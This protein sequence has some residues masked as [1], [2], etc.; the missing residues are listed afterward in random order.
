MNNCSID[1][2]DSKVGTKLRTLVG[3]NN[4]AY[5]NYVNKCF[6]DNGIKDD[7]KSWYKKTFKKE[8]KL[9]DRDFANRMIRYYNET[10][11]RVGKVLRDNA[12]SSS[13]R[14]FAYPSI[15]DR[16]EGIRH[17]VGF[18]LNHFIA[19]QNAG[20]S[21][22]GNKRDY[23]K[24]ILVSKYNDVIFN[25]IAN[26]NNKSIDVVKEEYNEA[27]NKHA[28]LEKEFGG[29]NITITGRNLLAVHDELNSEDTLTNYFNECLAN[30]NLQSVLRQVND[31]KEEDDIEAK[32]AEE[33]NDNNEEGN[34]D[35]ETHIKEDE[36][37]NFISAA[38]SHMGN[39]TSYTKHL[40]TKITNY[41]NSLYKLASPVEV[42][43]RY[44]YDTN[45]NFGIPETMDANECSMM[46][47]SHARF[48]NQDEMIASIEQIS[49]QVP[50][51]YAFS[52]FAN[53]LKNDRDLATEVF[54][55]FAKTIMEKV[56]TTLSDEVG[57]VRV[58]NE[59]ANPRSAMLY[60]MMNDARGTSIDIPIDIARDTISKISMDVRNAGIRL[61]RALESQDLT[62]QD[63]NDINDNV[64]RTL[65]TTINNIKNVI[66]AYFPTVQPQAIEQYINENNNAENDINTKLTNCTNLLNDINEIINGSEDT[67]ANYLQINAKIQDAKKH[68]DNLKH[69]IANNNFVDMN[70]MIDMSKLYDA[71][72]LSD[73]LNSGI[74]LLMEKLLP[75]STVNVSLNSRNV[76]GNQSSDVINN[77]MITYLTKMFRLSY[78]DAN[79]KIINEALS[80]WGRNRFRSHQ[81]DYSGIL[82]EHR[83]DNGN[84]INYGLF[85]DKEGTLSA[86][87]ENLINISLFNGTSN[88]DIDTNSMYT[89]QTKGDFLPTALINFFNTA[90]EVNGVQT[91]QDNAT[92]FLRT[93]SDAP[94]TFCI[95]A[96]KYNTNNF[97]TF[98]D[99]KANIDAIV[100]SYN[101]YEPTNPPVDYY[102]P[103]ENTVADISFRDLIKGLKN[104]GNL[105]IINEKAIKY[106]DKKTGEAVV[107]F[108]YKNDKD[109]RNKDLRNKANGKR[110]FFKG[111]VEKSGKA[112]Y[113]KDYTFDGIL[114]AEN[115]ELDEDIKNAIEGYYSKELKLHDITV[116]G[117]TYSQT[118]EQVNRESPLFTRFENEVK[119]ELL[120]TAI[121]IDHYFETTIDGN[122]IFDVDENGVRKP[123]FKSGASNTIGYRN[124]HLG[125]NGTVLEEVKKGNKVVG[126]RLAGRVFGSEK[127]TLN[128]DENGKVVHRNYIQEALFSDEDGSKVNDGKIHFLYGGAIA[129]ETG[130]YTGT[131]LN[132][133][134]DEDG[135]VTDIVLNDKQKETLDNALEQF[136][137]AYTKQANERIAP[138]KE[139]IKGVEYNKENVN[140]Y[141]INALLAHCTYDDLFE[142]STLFYKNGQDVLKRAKEYQGSGVPYGIVNYMDDDS[143]PNMEVE[144]SYLN[145]GVYNLKGKEE[146]RGEDGLLHNR[147]TVIPTSIQDIFKGTIFDGIKQ[148]TKFRAITI[149]NTERT[150]NAAAQNGPLV[151]YLTKVYKQSGVE[152]NK[153]REMANKLMEG[154]QGTK[155]NDAQSYITVQEWVRRIA[156]RGQLKRYMPLIQKLIK[157][158]P[159]SINEANEFV[160]VQKNFYYDMHYDS[161]YGIVVP[162]QIKNAEFVLVPQFIRG[163]EL[164]AVYNMMQKANLQQL[165]TVETSKAAN[166][167]LLTIW[168]NDGKMVGLTEEDGSVNTDDANSKFNQFVAKANELA[169][170]NEYSYKYLY[171][172]QETPQHLNA[173]NKFGIQI[174]KKIIDNIDL[175]D[176]ETINDNDNELTKNRKVL[177][178]IKRR[179]MNLVSENVRDSFNN[180]MEELE[181]ETDKDGNI[182]L[183]KGEI[184][185]MNKQIFYDKL[186]E[187]L[188]R[189]GADSN[190][191]DYVTLV[192][193]EPKMKAITVDK[194]TKFESVVQSVFNSRITRQKL[195]GFHVAQVTNMGFRRLGEMTGVNNVSYDKDLAYHP[196]DKNGNPQGYIEVRLPYSTFGIDIT[197]PYYKELR[198]GKT[199]AEFQDAILAELAENGLDTIIGYR[200]PTEGKQSVCNMKVV[201]FLDDTQ[202][203]TIIVPDDWVSQTGSDFDIDSVYGITQK[204]RT[205]K[206]GKVVPIKF[207]EG[208]VGIGQYAN[209]IRQFANDINSDN[210]DT[211]LG[212][213]K[214]VVKEAINKIF[215]ETKS[216]VGEAKAEIRADKQ[217]EYNS[218]MTEQNDAF[219]EF[220]TKSP[221]AKIMGNKNTPKSILGI[222]HIKQNQAVSKLDKDASKNDKFIAQLDVTN[223]TV[224]A[225][226][227]KFKIDITK[228][229][230]IS[231]FIESNEAII[232][233]LKNQKTEINELVDSELEEIF[234]NRQ[235]DLEDIASQ[236]GL[237]SFDDFKNEAINNPE[238]INSRDARTNE[239]FNCMKSILENPLALE[240]N[241]SRSNF[242]D[243]SDAL[244]EYMNPN[245]AAERTNRS[246]YNPFDQMSYQEEAM[247]GAKLKAFSVTLDTFCSVCNTVKPIL[248]KPIYVVYNKSDY[249]DPSIMQQRFMDSTTKNLK[250]SKTFGVRHTSYG[251]SADNKCAA[252]KILTAY[253]SQTTAYILDAIKSGAIPNVNDYTFAVFK[254]LANAGCDYKTSISFIMQ[255]GISR[256][257]NAYNSSHSVF[258]DYQG[259]NPINDAI[260]SIAKDLGYKV[261]NR[262]SVKS[263]LEK[264]DNDYHK[265][266]NK[267]FA[268]KGE[269]INIGLTYEDTENLPIIVDKQV[270]RLKDKGEFEL[271][272][273]TP[274][275]ELNKLN[276]KKALFDLGVVLS[277]NKLYYTANEIGDIARC[278]NPDK[279]GAKQDVYSTNKI[280]DDANDLITKHKKDIDGNEVT[281]A[282]I[283]VNKDGKRVHILESIYPGISE[284]TEDLSSAGI[285]TQ[286][287]INESSYPSLYSYLKYASGTSTVVAREVLPTQSIN[288]TRLVKGFANKLSGFDRALSPK[289]YKEVQSYA[290]SDFYNEAEFI[291]YPIAYST[292]E[293]GKLDI[294]LS[295][296]EN[297]EAI[298]NERKRIFGFGQNINLTIVKPRIEN[299][300]KKNNTINY[301]ISFEKYNTLSDEE[302]ANYE[303]VERKVYDNV[304]FTVE[305]IN[306]PTNEELASFATFS[307]AQKVQFI[308]SNFEDTGIFSKLKVSLY[309]PMSRGY[310]AGSQTIEYIQ[311]NSN[312]N[313][314]YQEFYNAFFDNNPL[315]AMTAYDLVKY[316]A[317]V[318]GFKMSQR[319]ISK[320]IDNRCLIG[321]FGNAGTGFQNSVYGRIVDFNRD[322]SHI[323][324]D[325][326]QDKLYEEFLRSHPNTD[327][328]KLYSV[329]K[330]NNDKYHLDNLSAD[331]VILRKD[332]TVEGRTDKEIDD[333][334]IERAEK[335]GFVTRNTADNSIHPNP[336]VKFKSKARGVE[337]Y[338]VEHIGDEIIAYPLNK[339]NQNEH[340]TWSANENYNIH[341]RSEAYQYI[342]A[343]Y[344]AEKENAIIDRDFI[345]DRIAEYKENKANPYYNSIHKTKSGTV[346][347]VLENMATG[348]DASS[349]AIMLRND[350]IKH[351][352]SLDAN[353]MFRVKSLMLSKYI[354]A[355]NDSSVQTISFP[356][357]SKRTFE[358]IKEDLSRYNGHFLGNK[359]SKENRL[360]SAK[361]IK[362]P[363]LNKLYTE[364][365][366]NDM[367]YVNDVYKVVDITTNDSSYANAATVEEAD[368]SALE[369]INLAQKGQRDIRTGLDGEAS[370]EVQATQQA[371]V[372][373]IKL[374]TDSIKN[375]VDDATRI[376]AEYAIKKGKE[377]ET[378]LNQF[379]EDPENPNTYL[380]ASDKRVIDIIKDKPLMINKFFKMLNEVNAYKARFAGYKSCE[381]STDSPAVKKYVE[382]I[383]K[384]YDNV[385][386]LDV[387]KANHNLM[388]NYIAKFSTNPLIREGVLDIADNFYKTYGSMWMFHDIAE[389]GNP[390]LQNILKDVYTHIEA[391]RMITDK[392]IREVKAHIKDIKRRAKAEGFNVDINKIVNANGM[393]I[394]D[395]SQE[396]LDKMTELRRLKNE[397]AKLGKGYGS[398][399]YL[400]AKNDYDQYKA[401][402][403]H[404]EAKQEYYI[405]KA[406]LER[407]MINKHPKIY[408]RYMT[409]LYKQL[410]IYNYMTENGIPE[411]KQAELDKIQE[412]MIN[413]SRPTEYY[414]ENGV[415]KLRPDERQDV[416]LNSEPEDYEAAS[417]YDIHEANVLNQFLT[418]MRML[419]GKYFE[420]SSK[421]GFEDLLNKNLSIVHNI[422]KPDANGVPTQ[423]QEVLNS[424]KEYLAA[425]KWIKENA[426][427]RV[428]VAKDEDGNPTN[429]LAQKIIDALQRLGLSG[430][431]NS[432]SLNSLLKHA[433]DDKGIKDASGVYNGQLLSSDE[434][435][436][437]KDEMAR[438][439]NIQYMPDGSD[440]ILI[441][442]TKPD[443]TILNTA[444]YSKFN[445]NK[446]VYTPEY[447]DVV[448]RINQIH[449]KYYNPID[450]TVRL[451][452]IPDNEEGYRE[453]D[454]LAELYQKYRK[455]TRSDEV[456]DD[457][458]KE[459]RSKYT[460]FKTNEDLY[461]EQVNEIKTKSVEFRNHATNVI[462]DRMIDGE[463]R[464]KS[465]DDSTNTL[466]P[467][468]IL[469]SYLTLNDELSEDEKNRYI[470]HYRNEDLNLL[471][472][473]YIK[474]P[475]IYWE[476]ALAEAHNRRDSDPSFDYN[477]WWNDNHVYNPYTRKMELLPCW[478][479]RVLNTEL[480]ENGAFIG[481]WEPKAN[482]R[483]KKV[484]DGNVKMEGLNQTYYMEDQDMRDKDYKQ[485]ASLAANYIKGAENGKYDNDVQLN[486]YEK[487]T[488]DFIQ[489]TLIKTAGN[490][491]SRRYFES[492]RLPQRRKGEEVDAK[493]AAKEFGKLLGFGISSNNG[494]KD[495]DEYVGYDNDVTPIMPML[496]DVVSAKPTKVMRMEELD[497]ALKSDRTIYL[498]KEV[499]VKP[500]RESYENDED[501]AKALAEY[502]TI[503]NEVKEHNDKVRKDNLDRDWIDV[504]GDY[505]SQAAR[506]N[507]IQDSK[508]KLYWLLNEL[509]HQQ[510]YIRK[511]GGSGDLRLDTRRS[512]EDN[513]VYQTALD[514]NLIKQYENQLRRLLWD[515]WKEPENRLTRWANQLQT[516]TSA[517]YMMLNI[518]GGISNVTLGVLQGITSEALSEEQFDKKDVA[519]GMAE[520]TKN[521]PSFAQGMY[522]VKGYS[523]AD[524]VIKA[525]KAVDYD[526][527][528]G[529]V[530]NAGL[531]KWSERVRN[532]GFSPQTV[533]EFFM[534]NSVLIAMLHNHKVVSVSNDDI[535]NIGYRIMNEREYFNYKKLELLKDILTE[536]QLTEYNKH[537]EEIK[538][539]P[540]LLK[541][542]A[543]FRKDLATEVIKNFDRKTRKEYAKRVKEAKDKVHK[544]FN[545]KQD[546][547]SQLELKDGYMSFKQDSDLAKLDEIPSNVEGED[548]TNAY[549]L[550]GE[551]SEKVR[552]T[553]NYIHGVYNRQGMAYI[554]KSW[555]GSLVMQYHK[556][557][558]MGLMKRY[559]SRGNWNEFRNNVN[560]GMIHS[561]IDFLK[562]DMD[563]VKTDCG[564]TDNEV[565]ALKGVQN[566]LTHSF[567]L[568]TNL[569]A[570]WE[571][572]P[573]YD[574]ANIKR[575]LGDLI[576]TLGGIMG[577]IALIAMGADDDDDEGSAMSI[578]K[579]LAL[580]ESDRLASESFMYNPIGMQ[581][582]VKTLMSTPLAA[583]SIITD[584]FKT[585]YEIGGFIMQGDD[586]DPI[587][588]SGRFAGES[589]ISVYVQRRIPMWSGIRGVIDSPANN[590]YYKVGD[591]VCSLVNTKGLGNWIGGRG[592]DYDNN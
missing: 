154:F 180:L 432:R 324:I 569:K 153:A 363:L 280:F 450:G 515:Q 545:D 131:Y 26:K 68:N 266:F 259:G 181:I 248:T 434:I 386:A 144:N 364:A 459:F 25:Y 220:K 441:N 172:Q 178:K 298:D 498:D 400:K 323:D 303:L 138:Y 414:V 580:Y 291:K 311:D 58:S 305:D 461:K 512:T 568:L 209:Y 284:T 165:N 263:I 241:L 233:F 346:D 15:A 49:L 488:R 412:E 505:L 279:F 466:V 575:N 38:N 236:N 308:K 164:E 103:G 452:N 482:Q 341:L 522:D 380:P 37:D 319:A 535:R 415:S 354:L 4:V 98:E 170:G 140:N 559:H 229:E 325:G 71:D 401:V 137:L 345:K 20:L 77:S 357:G 416:E 287:R 23:Y 243:I 150:S 446:K 544:E 592:Y 258:S 353:K 402:Y 347:F 64:T 96:P 378:R 53:D 464:Y 261:D 427:Y 425:K 55:T 8:C 329:T 87:A 332:R 365:I 471:D 438:R 572:T 232:D 486:D 214:K 237:L 149:K 530:R 494:R 571:I 359:T 39:F 435:K 295:D 286:N 191:M 128:V 376:V 212:N 480:M 219:D 117:V 75:Y 94:K 234:A 100:N 67:Q 328:I 583:Q 268:Q 541:D 34:P 36:G 70:D 69:E 187:E 290:L 477:A 379:V 156:A 421:Y 457:K 408:S 465:I 161:R 405:Q 57:N 251:W 483:I 189:T 320:V 523:L 417:I 360:A 389:N 549:K 206:D 11:L 473:A 576:G 309:N 10:S 574:K 182:V 202:G 101:R 86:E 278:C 524:A 231:N 511:Y 585:I 474:K 489:N 85:S 557:L 136:I 366:N 1:F 292:N 491:A 197:K 265:E 449:S 411:D 293:D 216:E 448:T 479:T 439:Y 221:F 269:E 142:G 431:G 81:Y 499:N 288:F 2:A 91:N 115:S 371:K 160:Q 294:H 17:S 277:F 485:D 7:F 79:G 503:N 395:Y 388:E 82:L 458:T 531:A 152:E 240:E 529:V 570:T 312:A 394:Q 326:S 273:N 141:A 27:D 123:R 397:A 419:N 579:N 318:E 5:W 29:K 392:R 255:P 361:T 271:K 476:R 502:E 317:V 215:D 111:V 410:D 105:L 127:F 151:D 247:S 107:S 162:R 420:Y 205:R 183:D 351:F 542:Y 78:K 54:S 194:I 116:N 270:A 356:D 536:E 171:T 33:S 590:H 157:E 481:K 331:M 125:K 3:N 586:F 119:Q 362:D 275:E 451:E 304:A 510:A 168:D 43:G 22:T 555:Y 83:D 225:L 443:S 175:L 267:I 76:Y 42:N 31:E 230:S 330:K 521:M 322:N 47:Y 66:K 507:A 134:K 453:L 426:Q 339:L 492:G 588:K 581:T 92:Y 370:L 314:I 226:A 245:I 532:A 437:V 374:K 539:D 399:E 561:C 135:N 44:D 13:V 334:F 478:T 146:Y 519:Y 468:R 203:S 302:K 224:K 342:V 315:V 52:K 407:E 228:N 80:N 143:T 333:E 367:K 51:F 475:T 147:D 423:A 159:L 198:K 391:K 132:T 185:N 122:V 469:Y 413:L 506:Y 377:L 349:A 184:T 301:T 167:E 383:N 573:D 534:Q 335:I 487:E 493:M 300:Y 358:I 110:Y 496:K 387:D 562:L 124:Y 186:K 174:A 207:V 547:Y 45:T 442:N 567:Q 239:V 566:I 514:E 9:T 95:R 455:L 73:K 447:Y 163:T 316:A 467:N 106:I 285:V 355:A 577:A 48:N 428:E 484:K 208:K 527:I 56:E 90:K 403:T 501:Y 218:L 210:E 244:K 173:Q 409:L 113:L 497:A 102:T 133:I 145:S 470:D 513:N 41:F 518:R 120:N 93:P 282:A 35:T 396:F 118:K 462:F 169:T 430:N 444:F 563:L 560:K 21:I 61:N 201:S 262:T 306:H 30:P 368:L 283:V 126:Y 14:T 242:D 429:P 352:N 445:A 65:S 565:S 336:Y 385:A 148:T 18:I 337:I 129:D 274:V 12:E 422:E 190:V 528:T 500:V 517:N 551:L 249:A 196:K 213:R 533:G 109:Y 6:D 433:N 490:H 321:E 516:F 564:L 508:E 130:H 504:I 84:I 350:I 260:K 193:G 463:L 552:K 543:W 99:D 548:V 550:L 108:A 166:E 192:N 436:S 509:K 454:E 223:K 238:R 59:A 520:I 195:P 63:K 257:V 537:K 381:I 204:V 217:E 50:G 375:N 340:G 556:H 289:T 589:K 540:N 587:Y 297:D 369:F 424:N 338:K 19:V 553:N 558:P 307:P 253:S 246:A 418:D 310:R 404:Q 74:R 327:G 372:Q 591:R 227:N 158:E 104:E 276:T 121:A 582:E 440:R 60:D 296:V 546:V 525:F 256:I 390:L 393:L 584:A 200:I 382:D 40:G 554:E 139:F 460:Q 254:T 495:F 578:A 179:Y 384:A 348:E 398:I 272:E 313:L 526:E 16:E 112:L 114:G 281:D 299:R 177:S 472:K 32:D 252:G 72:Y 235:A 406:Y 373:G 89:D 264:I 62:E 343:Q 199:D 176:D 88:T 456:P 97:I 188:V 344:K 211:K 222:I 28:Y 46:L 155:V 538:K 250:A 24:N